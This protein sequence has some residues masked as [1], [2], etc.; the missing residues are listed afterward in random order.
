V[1]GKDNFSLV[2]LVADGT[3]IPFL[4]SMHTFLMFADKMWCEETLAT[5]VTSLAFLPMSFYMQI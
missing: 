3:L 5:D 2:T 1:T 4:I